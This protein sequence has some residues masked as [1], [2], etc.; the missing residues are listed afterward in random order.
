VG[1]EET[2]GVG[3]K[4]V[5]VQLTLALTLTLVQGAA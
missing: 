2:I 5:G 1:R 3:G 4:R